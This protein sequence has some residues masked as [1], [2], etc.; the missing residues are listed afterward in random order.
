MTTTFDFGAGPVPAHKHK[1]GGGWVADSASVAESVY[2]GPQARISGT[3]RMS[4][5]VI[6]GGVIYGGVISGGVISGDAQISIS[7]DLLHGVAHGFQ[8]TATRNANH[9]W[10]LRFGCERHALKAWAK[11]HVKLATEHNKPHMAR[12][13]RAICALVKAA[14]V[15]KGS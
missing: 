13:T 5:G 3:A 7:A 10:T 4:G 11:L 6:Y 14:M 1:N 8:W 9:V 12:V 2:V 15:K